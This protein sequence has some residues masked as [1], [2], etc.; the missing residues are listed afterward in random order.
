MAA[1]K[2]TPAQ[3]MGG[4]IE[5][6]MSAEGINGLAL[7]KRMKL[8]KSVVYDDLKDPDRIPQHRLWLYL[9]VLGVDCQQV[10]APV[11]HAIADQMIIR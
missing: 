3:I 9:T 6:A 8:S 4:I 7:A 2:K 1:Y 10:L 5:A 11:A